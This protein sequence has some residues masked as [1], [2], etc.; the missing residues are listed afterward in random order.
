LEGQITQLLRRVRA[1]DSVAANELMPTV[2]AELRRIAARHLR[3]E[4][5]DHTLSPTA[6]V[7]EAYVRLFEDG[8]PDF[9]DRAHFMA[10]ATRVMRGILVDYARTRGCAKRG[11]DNPRVP[12]EPNLDAAVD[13]SDLRPLLLDL[14]RAIDTLTQENPSLAE[15]IEMRYFGGMTAE[16]T[17]E[18][19][20]RSVHIVRHE[21][22]LAQ[23]WLRRELAGAAAGDA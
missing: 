16:E 15:V 6:L 13:D 23:A 19:V 2:Y 3:R 7:N 22:R 17:S 1:G 4:R 5:R 20:G 14:D 18:V 9:S 21:L 11:G 12:L 8:S 10:L